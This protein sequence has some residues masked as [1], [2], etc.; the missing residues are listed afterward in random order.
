MMSTPGTDY[1]RQSLL[2][3]VR[4]GTISNKR[5]NIGVLQIA[6]DYLGTTLYSLLFNALGCVGVNS[7]VFVPVCIGNSSYGVKDSQSNDTVYS[8]IISPCFSS[9]DRIL[10]YSKQRKIHNSIC[11]NIDMGAIDVIHAHTLF[12]AGYTARRLKKEYGI[13]YIVAIRN[14]DVNV[15]FK[16]MRHLRRAGINIMLDADK[17]IF[18]SPSYK[19]TVI[20]KYIPVEKQSEIREKSIVIPNGISDF[21]I[22][23]EPISGDEEDTKRLNLG[24]ATGKRINIIYA[25]EVNH[26]KN[27]IETV[28]ACKLLISKGYDCRYTVVGDITDKKCSGILDENF[29]TYHHKC[30]HDELIMLYRRNDIF[31]MPSHKE[32]F[33]LV[34][35]EAMSQGLPVIYTKGQ[36]FDGQF[37]EGV[38]GYSVS[39]NDAQE[40]ADKIE[41]VLCNYEKIS[42]RCIEESKR[43]NWHRIAEEYKNIYRSTAN[44]C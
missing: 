27:L 6:N 4:N 23:N 1:V 28:D 38:V 11:R 42:T 8:M 40:L 41:L 37:E 29:I 12:S 32:T 31:V 35:A 26:N 39:D 43:F 9:L 34:Y 5:D 19:D 3:D 44:G 24:L 17:I 22:H 14:V 36:G 15:F 10:F 16:K 25:G 2:E 7:V 18:L 13:P 33:G 30:K 21:F 20:E